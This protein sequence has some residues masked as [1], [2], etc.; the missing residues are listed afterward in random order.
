MAVE[1]NASW[2]CVGYQFEKEQYKI[3]IKD[4]QFTGVVC[5]NPVKGTV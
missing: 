4:E 3:M 1:L 5:C 2:V